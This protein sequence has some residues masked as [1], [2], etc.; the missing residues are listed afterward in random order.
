MDT[1]MN[2]HTHSDAQGDALEYAQKC[3]KAVKSCRLVLHFALL[4]SV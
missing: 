3:P 1:Y 4:S 2:M